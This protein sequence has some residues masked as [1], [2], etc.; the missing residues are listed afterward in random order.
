MGKDGTAQWN[1]MKPSRTEERRTAVRGW[2]EDPGRKDAAARS[3]TAPTID[4]PAPIGGAAVYAA[5]IRNGEKSSGPGT[6]EYASFVIVGAVA[7]AAVVAGIVVRRPRR[8]AGGRKEAR[9]EGREGTVLSGHRSGGGRRRR[10]APRLS[11]N[12]RE[13]RA[14]VEL[15]PFEPGDELVLEGRDDRAGNDLAREQHVRPRL[16]VR[17]IFHETRP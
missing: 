8:S 13:Q 2:T 16:N 11:R 15:A 14:D 4:A 12:L 5:R 3:N 7:L 9:Q 10:P 6:R 1:P 17:K